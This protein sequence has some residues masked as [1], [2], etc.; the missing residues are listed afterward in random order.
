MENKSFSQKLVIVL[1]AIVGVAI[2]AEL[3]AVLVFPQHQVEPLR[4]RIKASDSMKPNDFTELKKNAQKQKTLIS[5]G[6]QALDRNKPNN[7]AASKASV[8]KKTA[9]IDQAAL[10][11][12]ELE[13]LAQIN[14]NNITE[15]EKFAQQKT[16]IDTENSVRTSLIQAL[17]GT[18]ATFATSI[19]AFVAF[20]NYQET[21]KKNIADRFSKAVE[22]LG[23]KE[24]N[25]RLGGIFALEQIAKSEDEYYGQ[26]ME[27]LTAY[28]R[29]QSPWPEKEDKKRQVDPLT[30]SLSKL[31]E[32]IQAVMTVL[33]RRRFSYQQKEEHRLDLHAVDLRNLQLTEN[34]KLQG[35]DFQGSCLND[36]FMNKVRLEGAD[37]R[38]AHLEGANLRYAHL[39][40]ANLRYAHLEGADLC[41]ACLQKACVNNGCFNN[42]QFFQAKLQEVDFTKSKLEGAK[43]NEAEM[44]ESNL[45]G[46]TLQGAIFL[47]ACLTEASLRHADCRKAQFGG[48]KLEKAWLESA[49]FGS[50]NP[51]DDAIGLTQEQLSSA[52]FD[53]NTILPSYLRLNGRNSTKRR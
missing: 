50:E 28:V 34:A 36:A 1:L 25:V 53:K 37:L 9:L 7:S 30:G 2:I 43:F 16:L 13:A 24:T 45:E 15:T 6:I 5:S 33:S 49:K 3:G 29:E 42:A 20:Q 23:H 10:I 17:V 8:Q 31:A 51:G 52:N 41:Y 44:E 47:N 26:I 11:D 38:Y 46:A 22:M 32:D 21:Q 39:E 48:A 18:L 40:G 12:A 35:V 4:S 19:A 14:L 27:I